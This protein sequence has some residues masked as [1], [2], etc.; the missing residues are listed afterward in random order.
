MKLLC[1]TPVER[2]NYRVSLLWDLLFPRDSMDVTHLRQLF[3]DC[4][5]TPFSVE[6]GPMGKYPAAY[7]LIFQN[8][9]TLKEKG[10][11][12]KLLD[13]SSVVCYLC[14]KRSAWLLTEKITQ[15]IH[16]IGKKYFTQCRRGAPEFLCI[17]QCS[18]P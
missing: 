3:L 16:S 14:Y 1:A 18:H 15:K 17:S 2:N 8:M 9:R 11:L 7:T 13:L 4:K 6:D 10:I 12:K 5:N